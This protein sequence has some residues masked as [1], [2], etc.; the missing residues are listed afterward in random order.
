[1]VFINPSWSRVKQAGSHVKQEIHFFD[2]TNNP[3]AKISATN[4]LKRFQPFLVSYFFVLLSDF[5]IPFYSFLR[6]KVNNLTA[7]YSIKHN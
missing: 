6:N 7:Y 1:M 3:K 4:L 5:E 2:Y